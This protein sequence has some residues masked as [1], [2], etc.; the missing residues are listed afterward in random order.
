MKTFAVV[1]IAAVLTGCG[2][3]AEDARE[4]IYEE[5][6]ADGRADG[7]AECIEMGFDACKIEIE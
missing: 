3:S 6:Y 2:E 7:M 4:S 5:A 1:L